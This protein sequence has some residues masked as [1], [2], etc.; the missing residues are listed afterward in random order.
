MQPAEFIQVESLE[1]QSVGF[2]LKVKVADIK[3]IRNRTNL[4]GT[5]L[6]IAEALVGDSTGCVYLSL[7]NDQIEMIKKD[8]VVSLRNGKIDMVKN[9]FMRV[10]IDRWGVIEHDTTAKDFKDEIKLDNNL[11]TVEYELVR[12]DNN[13]QQSPNRQNRQR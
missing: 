1:P 13:Q 2:N 10:A 12:E 5:K 4:D 9:G 7:R 6:R 3:L 11:S 8:D